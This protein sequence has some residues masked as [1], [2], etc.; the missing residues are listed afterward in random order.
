[1]DGS[2]GVAAVEL[3]S[4]NGGSQINFSTAA[5]NTTPAN[6]MTILNNG[7]IGMGV[8]NPS[9]K[10][11][12]A[13]RMSTTAIVSG[14]LIAGNIYSN[15]S[16]SPSYILI[17]DLNEVAGFSMSGKVNAASYT[18]WN[19]S[20]IWI[21]KDYSSTTARAGI[22]GSYKS[23]C[24]F[25]IVDISYGAGR[26]VALRFTS[27][28]EIDVMFTG[29]RLADLYQSDGTATV[30]TSGVTVNGTYASY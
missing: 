25:S 30:A 28:P 27:N 15:I 29:Y 12:V 22:V 26:Y 6:R 2:V 20:D 8:T 18:C 24:D 21:E 16:T 19:I 17:T 9:K 14:N 11:T 1:L 5:S 3:Y 4:F 23:G 13:G 10:L 7:N